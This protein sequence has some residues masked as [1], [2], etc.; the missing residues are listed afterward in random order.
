MSPGLKFVVTDFGPAANTPTCAVPLMKYTHSS[1]LGC[2]C[3]SREAPGRRVT[4]AEAMVFETWKLLLSAICTVPAAV[5]RAKGW[6]FREKVNGFFGAPLELSTA[7]WS[8]A[9]CPGRSL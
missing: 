7:A 8:A 3:S 2:Q 9:S 6:P 4:S 1:A 5:S